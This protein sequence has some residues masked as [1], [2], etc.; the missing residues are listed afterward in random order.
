MLKV[1]RTQCQSCIYLTPSPLDL[2]RL[3]AEIADPHMEGHFS[4]YR[5]CHHSTDVC[6]RGFFDRHA[7]DCTPIQIAQRLG[8]VE[9][10]EV[11]TLRKGA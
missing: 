1:Q 8:L 2:Q 3:E 5:I 4:S 9:F 6:C 10:V 11:D 7:Q